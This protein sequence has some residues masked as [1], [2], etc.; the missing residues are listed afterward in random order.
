[1]G[2]FITSAAFL[3]APFLVP[4]D[5]K[6]QEPKAEDANPAKPAAAAGN[7]QYKLISLAPVMNG[8]DFKQMEDTLNRLGADGWKV[9]TGV[10]VALV[11]SK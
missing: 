4:P 8:R 1:M 7:E 11:L 2:A 9:R 10:G 6:A 5:A 3:G